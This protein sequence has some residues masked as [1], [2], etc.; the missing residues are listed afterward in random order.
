MS[1]GNP[2]PSELSTPE[3]LALTTKLKEQGIENISLSGGEPVQHKDFFKIAQSFI[4]KGFKVSVIT[5]AT[6]SEAY[7][8]KF[9][10]VKFDKI[11]I[12]LDGLENTHNL[13][14]RS[15]LSYKRVMN[16]L[17][18]LSLSSTLE[19][20][21]QRAVSRLRRT[22]DR[23]VLNV[24]EDHEDDEN[25]E[26]GVVQRSLNISVI[27]CVN[28]H[29]IKDLEGLHEELLNY[30]ISEWLLRPVEML[31]RAKEHPELFL[32]DSDKKLL[33]AFL[34]KNFHEAGENA[35]N[36][37]VQLSL[38]ENMSEIK[39][40]AKPSLYSRPENLL[41]IMANGEFRPLRQSA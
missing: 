34:K 5:N 37:V 36:R 8:E 29:S 24:H 4:D 28:S 7:Y 11:Y 15:G 18:F 33:E 25:A 27:T 32:S 12:S 17:Q 40:N 39:L 19:T 26:N 9:L 22:N 13:F 6:F 16:F 31:G 21:A 35:E 30:R 38:N 14:R 1:S 3:I 2:L 23:S 20:A 41:E 10:D